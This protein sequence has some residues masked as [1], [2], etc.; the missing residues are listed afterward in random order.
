MPRSITTATARSPPATSP[1]SAPAS[2]AWCR[3]TAVAS[4]LR[5]SPYCGIARDTRCQ[6]PCAKP[7]EIATYGRSLFRCV[8]GGGRSAL[9]RKECNQCKLCN[10]FER[11]KQRNE[12]KECNEWRE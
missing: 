9:V 3:K 4:R 10:E 1:S 8:F 6:S 12:G 2:A 11:N 5:P 7:R